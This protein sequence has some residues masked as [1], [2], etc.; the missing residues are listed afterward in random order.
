MML[1]SLEASELKPLEISG[2]PLSSTAIVAVLLF[3][4]TDIY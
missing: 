2:G 4:T 3:V 1:E